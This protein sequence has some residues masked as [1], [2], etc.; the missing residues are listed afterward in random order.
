MVAKAAANQAASTAAGRLEIL[1]LE[2]F[3]PAAPWETRSSV[4]T[5]VA[6]NAL[7]HAQ[8][9]AAQCRC[10]DTLPADVFFQYDVKTGTLNFSTTMTPPAPAIAARARKPSDLAA[11]HGQECIS[12]RV[13]RSATGV[14]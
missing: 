14:S 5:P 2:T 7:V 11:V 12:T 13:R 6:L 10:R 3:A 4:S 8:R 1:A 9:G